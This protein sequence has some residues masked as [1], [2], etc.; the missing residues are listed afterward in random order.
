MIRVILTKLFNRSGIAVQ[1]NG[2]GG[3]KRWMVYLNIMEIAPD[4]LVLVGSSQT[5]QFIAREKW[6][7]I[8]KP[9]F[10]QMSLLKV[11]S[12]FAQ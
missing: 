5:V 3:L 1:W 4:S 12:A 7:V 2:G 10:L 6:H 8:R 11:D 9:L